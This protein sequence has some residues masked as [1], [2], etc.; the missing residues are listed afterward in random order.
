MK[1]YLVM[2]CAFAGAIALSACGKEK[3]DD[4]KKPNNSPVE[5][6]SATYFGEKY[7][8]GLAVYEIVLSKGTDKMRIQLVSDLPSDVNKARPTS[9]V[10]KKGLFAPGTADK[11]ENKTYIVATDT[12][13]DYGTLYYDNGVATLVNGGTVK[14]SSSG[15]GGTIITANLETAE[16]ALDEW[17]FNTSQI[18]YDVELAPVQQPAIAVTDFAFYYNGKYNLATTTDMDYVQLACMSAENPEYVLWLNIT[19]PTADD[20]DKVTLAPGEYSVAPYDAVKVNQCVAGM[21]DGGYLHPSYEVLFN[22]TGNQVGYVL[23][24]SGKVTVTKNGDNYNI[25]TDL[26]GTAYDF[27]GKETGK[28]DGI[29]FNFVNAPLGYALDSTR[30]SSSLEGDLDLGEIT[31]LHT[32]DMFYID[33]DNQN[34][35]LVWRFLAGD[36]SVDLR[37]GQDYETTGALE[38]WGTGNI[39]DLQFSTPFMDKGL[40]TGRFEMFDKIMTMNLATQIPQNVALTANIDMQ[41][42]LAAGAGCW[43]AEI[44][45]DEENGRLY[46]SGGA[47]AM[48]SKGF[49]EITQDGNVYTFVFEFYDKYDHKISGSF[50]VTMQTED[51]Q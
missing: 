10:Y 7:G 2:L 13:D 8:S 25:T 49:I 46:Q 6:E 9:A 51:Q 33:S 50:K 16:G 1:K 42:A 34:A 28:R 41:D 5:L 36:E 11:P 48:P 40:P 14:Y 22:S 4:G 20:P 43:W 37:E 44:S 29:V 15:T 26:A 39:I 23:I 21:V 19:V 12:A 27:T 18:E 30:P 3:P 24:E 17:K 38:C 32:P 45:R 47:G 31:L 35:G